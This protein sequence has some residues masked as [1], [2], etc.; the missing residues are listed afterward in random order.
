MSIELKLR[1]PLIEC[2]NRS[3][4]LQEFRGVTVLKLRDGREYSY[5]KI[6]Y[7]HVTNRAVLFL[8]NVIVNHIVLFDLSRTGY[9]AEIY[10]DSGRV[11]YKS[12][13]AMEVDYYIFPKELKGKLVKDRYDNVHKIKSTKGKT[14]EIVDKFGNS[15]IIDKYLA[16]GWKLVVVEKISTADANSLGNT[17]NT[18]N[19]NWE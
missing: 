3:L 1:K 2:M 12:Q 10:L 7:N 18:G 5:N 6:R 4:I 15:E 16:E 17:D 8:N 11:L 19:L 9:K 13:G 14:L